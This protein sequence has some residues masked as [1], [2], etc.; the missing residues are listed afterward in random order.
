MGPPRSEW[1]RGRIRG[2][3]GTPCRGG[4]RAA[5]G[6]TGPDVRGRAAPAD[7]LRRA[8]RAFTL[9]ELLIVIVL[10]GILAALVVPRLARANLWGSE[11]KAAAKHV[12]ATLRLAR[13]RAID[14]AADNP[15]GY[16]FQGFAAAYRVEE[17]GGISYGDLHELPDGWQFEL[18][19][20]AVWFDP[21]GGVQ[22][23]I[24]PDTTLA[25]RKGG[26]RWLVR[27]DAATGY[28]WYEEG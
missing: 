15:L 28:A 3:A 20:Y 9:P 22:G 23:W 18:S 24:A 6:R 10:M 1:L 17:T 16:K 5:P 12:A 13:Q 2:G 14:H 25:I 26:E 21:Y 19:N 27:F 4:V 8:R 11:G 7:R